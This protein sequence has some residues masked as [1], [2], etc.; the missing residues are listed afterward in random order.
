[1]NPSFYN[2]DLL[3]SNT[4]G[5][6][7]HTPD[8]PGKAD[9]LVLWQEKDRPA[10]ELESFLVRI[11]SALDR[12]P[13]QDTLL[14]VLPENARFNLAKSLQKWQ[15]RRAVVFG[16]PTRALGMS[17]RPPLYQP[18]P[19]GDRYYLWAD[20]LEKIEKER[21][22]GKATMSRPLWISLK[23]LLKMNP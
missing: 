21:A 4:L 8:G 19:L 22:A 23:E 3:I 12:T 10:G 16:I 17:I 15:V 14:A 1:M 7:A 5:E 18:F 2:F 11:L 13:G 9:L 6:I 20:P